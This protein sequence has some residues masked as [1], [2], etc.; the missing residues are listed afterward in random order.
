MGFGNLANVGSCALLSLVI[1]N[2]LYVAN[3]GDSKGVLISNIIRKK[4]W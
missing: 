2:K 3:L 1:D 4:W